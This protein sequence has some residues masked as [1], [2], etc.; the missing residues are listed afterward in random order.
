MA[1][2]GVDAPSAP[3]VLDPFACCTRETGMG[4]DV[5]CL[6]SCVLGPGFP[7][8]GCVDHASPLSFLR[9]AP[10]GPPGRLVLVVSFVVAV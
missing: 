8:A 6:C 7:P 5:W 9:W 1:T 2:I 4:R 3:R 10:A